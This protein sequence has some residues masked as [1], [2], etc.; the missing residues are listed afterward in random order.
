MTAEEF[1]QM[2]DSDEFE[3]R[4]DCGVCQPTTSFTLADKES[5]I[6]SIA[7]HYT[8]YSCKGE[9]DELK[10]GLSSLNFLDLLKQNDCIRSLLEGRDSSLTTH[11]L[12]DIFVP[13]FSPRGSNSRAAE[14][15][16]MMFFL[17]LL[18]EIEGRYISDE[19]HAFL[20]MFM[21][22]RHFHQFRF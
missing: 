14:E 7:L 6:S 19:T 21:H 17:D 16:T 2:L 5:I 11:C 18:H 10:L 1:K 4:F 12:Q 8:I 13:Q 20:C 9:L 15:A 22:Q 3:F